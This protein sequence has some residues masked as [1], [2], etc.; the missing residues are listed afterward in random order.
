[1]SP[2]AAPIRKKKGHRF[3]VYCT[4]GM[5]LPQRMTTGLHFLRTPNRTN[6]EIIG[7]FCAF[8]GRLFVAALLDIHLRT[9]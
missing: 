7:S 6:S 1:M 8:F 2:K 4:C 9:R 3:I 5:L